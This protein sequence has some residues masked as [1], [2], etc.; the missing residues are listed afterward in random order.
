M[1]KY[2]Y[3]LFGFVGYSESEIMLK[4]IKE[5]KFTLETNTFC[6]NKGQWAFIVDIYLIEVNVIIY[7]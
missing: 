4:T 3:K 5:A 1:V 6:N 2:V 7:M